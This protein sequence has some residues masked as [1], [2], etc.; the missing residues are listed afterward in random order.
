M[1]LGGRLVPDLGHFAPDDVC[2]NTWLTELHAVARTFQASS[3]GRHVFDEG[4]QGQPAFLFERAGDLAFF[5]ISAGSG[6]GRAN[7]DWQR[8]EFSPKD[9]LNEHKQF[10]DSF[11][12]TIRAAAK[13]ARKWIVQNVPNV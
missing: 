13:G 7:P 2:F 5:S 4:E 12:T 10:C 9:F 3:S 11:L 1:E 6:G 8:V